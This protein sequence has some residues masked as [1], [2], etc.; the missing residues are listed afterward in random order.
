MKKTIAVLLCLIF[1]FSSKAEMIENTEML[2]LYAEQ[3]SQTRVLMSELNK[4]MKTTEAVFDLAK[5]MDGVTPEVVAISKHLLQIKER[6]DELY[7]KSPTITPFSSCRTL[8][9]IAYSYWLTKL[10]SLKSE[11]DKHLDEAFRQY[12]KSAKEC[13]KQ[14]KTPPPKMVQELQIIDVP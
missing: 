6:A 1:S 5:Y 10:Q 2:S 13:S 8:T 4:V 14:I 12:N 3:K 7:G 9:G 11:N